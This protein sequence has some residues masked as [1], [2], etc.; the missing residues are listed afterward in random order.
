MTTLKVCDETVC[1]LGEGIFWNP[2]RHSFGWF[3]ILNAKFYEQ[4][5]DQAVRVRNCPGMA[6]AAARIDATRLLVVVEDGLYIL[7]L[8]TDHWERYLSLEAENPITRSND[9]RV[10][11]SGAFWVGTM[12]RKAEPKAGGIY[13]LLKGNLQ[14][15]YPNVT[16]PNA[17]CFTPDGTLGYFADSAERT[18]WRVQLDPSTG[19][20]VQEREIFLQ[21]PEGVS[22]DGAVV[23]EDGNFWIALWGGS[24]VAAYRPDGSLLLELPLSASQPSC[25]AFGGIA[26]SEL[27]VT[28]ALENLDPAARTLQPD[29][30]KVFGAPTEYRGQTEA[31]VLL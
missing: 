6:S 19:L 11:P 2:D 25:P 12:G 31:Y 27:R 26:C 10:H 4:V 13:H 24:R 7:D 21:T 28:T 3:D 9:S 14:L 22:P 20:P 1:E 16:I 18:V 30:G 17:T 23:D 29:G 5:R 8:R 15:L